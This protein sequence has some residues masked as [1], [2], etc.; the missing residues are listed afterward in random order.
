MK[1]RAGGRL[2][3]RNPM[4]APERAKQTRADMGRPR[5]RAMNPKARDAARL[6]VEERPS[7]P[8]IRFTALETPT[9]QKIDSRMERGGKL[10]T[11]EVKG[12]ARR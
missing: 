5:A 9:S 6:T 10:I 1:I 4:I 11:R 3:N 7:I 8:S 12:R 2:K